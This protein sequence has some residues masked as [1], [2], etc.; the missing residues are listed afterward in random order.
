MQTLKAHGRVNHKHMR[1]KRRDLIITKEVIINFIQ[2]SRLELSNLD[3]E[4]M[5]AASVNLPCRLH[6]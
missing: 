3:L 5:G 2:P 6:C 1:K 4:G